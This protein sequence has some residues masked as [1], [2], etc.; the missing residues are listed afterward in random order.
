MLILSE[1]QLAALN[2]EF[3]KAYLE[4]LLLL[5]RE[6]FSDTAEVPTA[7]LRQGVV[8]EIDKARGYGLLN[9]DEIAVYVVTA[10]QLGR[11]FDGFFPAAKLVLGSNDYGGAE[12]RDW[13][14]GWT[15]AMFNALQGEGEPWLGVTH[16]RR[17]R[18]S[19]P[20]NGLRRRSSMPTSGARQ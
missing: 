12:K 1:N 15:L 7:E 8:E 14:Q 17:T 18:L 19:M 13:L 16:S 10:W 6:Y 4:R 20:T 9:E 3:E 2:A 11:D 5:L